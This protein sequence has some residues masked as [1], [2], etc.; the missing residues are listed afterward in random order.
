MRLGFA[1]NASIPQLNRE[2]ARQRTEAL[3][4]IIEGLQAR[5]ITSL[6]ALGR[7][8]GLAPVSFSR[9]LERLAAPAA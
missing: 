9:V 6:R 2:R 3:R 5:G 1:R 7:G 4:P 8:L